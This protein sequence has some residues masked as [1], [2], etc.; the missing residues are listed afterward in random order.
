MIQDMSV[1]P[2]VRGSLLA[3]VRVMCI[4]VCTYVYIYICLTWT[5]GSPISESP[6]MN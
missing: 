3:D 2:K 1:F 4:H 6:H 5:C